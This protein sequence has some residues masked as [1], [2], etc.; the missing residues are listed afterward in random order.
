MTGRSALRA[1]LTLSLAFTACGTAAAQTSEPAASTGQAQEP[2]QPAPEGT[3]PAASGQD[4]L[5]AVEVIT[6]NEPVA[7]PP[8]PKA[9]KKVSKP[10]AAPSAPQAATAGTS[11]AQGTGQ[12]DAPLGAPATGGDAPSSGGEATAFSPVNGYVASR[13]ASGTKT[14]T[15][16][17]EIPQ[18]IT[19]VGR[20]QMEDQGVQS[21]QEAL[22]YAPST[23]A[24]LYGEDTRNDGFAIRGQEATVVFLDG[25]RRFYG[26]YLNAPRIEPYGL[27]RI[28]ILR[29]PS[30][31]LYGQSGVGGTVNMVSKL[32][33]DEFGGEIGAFYG[34]HD[35][36]EVRFDVTGPATS[37]HRWTYRLVGLGRDA[38]TQVDYVA[39]D[40]L[41]LAPSLTFR[42]SADTSLTLLGHVGR[43]R[44]GSTAQ[45][46][47]HE[48]TL[49][50][51]PNGRI[52]INRNVG[53]PDTD[54]YDA[55]TWS[56]TFLGDHKFDETWSVH[57]GLRYSYSDISY[58]QM[59]LYYPDPVDPFT[60]WDSDRRNMAR[61]LTLSM[62]DTKTFTSDTNA[63]AKFDLGGSRHKLL[64]GVDYSRAEVSRIRDT[65]VTDCNAF[66]D[67]YD[68]VY[69]QFTPCDFDLNPLDGIPLET[70]PD[71]TQWQTGLY[72]QDQIYLGPWIA[73]V[74][75]RKDWTATETVGAPDEEADALSKRAGLMYELPFG[76]TPYVSYAESFVPV[77]GSDCQDRP[78]K[79]LEGKSTEAG[80]KYETPDKGFVINSAVY[81]ATEENRLAQDPDPLCF[82]Y[83]VQTAEVSL[84]GFE[85]EARGDLTENIRIIAGY[86]YLEAEHVAGDQKGF[87]VESLPENVASLWAVYTF[88]EGA[89]RGFSFGGGVRYNGSSWDGYDE[90]K[91]PSFTLFDA[92]LA[93]ETEGWRWSL[94]ATNLEDEYHAT[95]CLN[96]GDCFLGA[97]RKIITGLTYKF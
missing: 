96:R 41:F 35:S 70:L 5:P 9:Q 92:M 83:S 84:R 36:K 37:D 77:T 16:L 81:D 34:S 91:T 76:L 45:F 62:T 30:A 13:S 39:D 54:H 80:F 40:R 46:L 90:I 71:R 29:G 75:L 89:L 51:G 12:S 10:T 22:R 31:V 67:L 56:V 14:D 72:V 50:R 55:D 28:E 42:P 74:G 65:G 63:L 8:K 78:F 44:S 82:E 26:N 7:P 95:T 85:I 69:G 73:V 27:E 1:L 33:Q 17:I 61:D 6:D 43:D 53:E 57:Q 15:P 18:G 79:P 94:N 88:H 93:Y 60:D 49:F 86:S 64:F 66:F 97:G 59:L 47:P 52:P 23:I 32:P 11:A 3:T 4:T 68:P 87:R 20:E 21:L 48:G 58:R 24:D 38:D 19:V 25:M 2:V